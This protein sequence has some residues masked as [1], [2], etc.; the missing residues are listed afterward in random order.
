MR[1]EFAKNRRIFNGL[2]K[3]EFDFKKV[4]PYNPM[5]FHQGG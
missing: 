4:V 5:K 3:K 1:V 2:A